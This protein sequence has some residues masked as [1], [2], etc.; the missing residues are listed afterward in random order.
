[1]RVDVAF[2]GA[3]LANGLIAYRLAQLRPEL[4]LLL[5]ERDLEIGG[6]HTWSFHGGDVSPEA[7][8]WLEPF[9]AHRWSGQEV[10]FPGR[11]RFLSAG[12][13]TITADSFRA[14][15]NRALGASIRTGVGVARLEAT[16]LALEDGRSI[17]AG[18]VLDGR[19]AASSPHLRLGFQKF[20]GLEVQTET[21]HG[22]TAPLI[23]DATVA[24]E[25][26]YRFVYV[27]PLAADR[28]LIEDTY[29]SDAD[30]LD[31]EPIRARIRDYAAAQGWRIARVLREETGVLPLLM[32]GDID[33]FLAAGP[34][35]V[36][37]T[38]LA[39]AFCHPVTGYSLPDAVRLAE[40]IAALP[41]HD[42]GAVSRAVAAHARRRWREQRFLR[43]LARLLFLAASPDRRW[44]V[45]K[46]FYGLPEPL[47]DR[48]Y[49]GRSTFLDKVRTLSGK[50]PVPIGMALRVL[51]EAPVLRAERINA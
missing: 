27:L 51:R 30:R 41:R 44:R 12:Y 47:I 22:R 38:G 23:M 26:G 35:G 16:G 46:R 34:P 43:L 14:E 48:F 17:E 9:V 6:Q 19:G 45:L 37:R 31:R 42:G 8:A 7:M 15:M 13:C 24:Q 4:S 18:A 32:A 11:T 5:L 1:M 50:P 33:K 40:L 3:G 21:P 20:V 49:A 29:Y 10:R 28:L 39:G 36:A 25:D 2:A